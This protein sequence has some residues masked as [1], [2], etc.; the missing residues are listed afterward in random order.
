MI[1]VEIGCSSLRRENFN[2][3]NNN[4]AMRAQLDLIEERRAIAQLR[5]AAY[6]QRAARYYNK[7][8]KEVKLREGDLVLRKVFPKDHTVLGPNWEGPYKIA[9]VIRP[10]SYRLC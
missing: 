5:V 8:V 9:K 2:Y 1:P 4:D 3:K 7:K 6:Q 10:G